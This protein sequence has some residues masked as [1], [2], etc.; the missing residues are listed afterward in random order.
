MTKRT[1]LQAF[2]RKALGVIFLTNLEQRH[3][4]AAATGAPQ[5]KWQTCS[6]VPCLL[7]N[8]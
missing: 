6:E 8:C 1:G 7:G 2:S 3:A 4:C 5:K